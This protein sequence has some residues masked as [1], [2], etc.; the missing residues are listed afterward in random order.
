MSDS[1][2]SR[3][4]KNADDKTQTSPDINRF[5]VMSSLANDRDLSISPP[6]EKLRRTPIKI[7]ESSEISNPKKMGFYENNIQKLMN[8]YPRQIYS[9]SSPGPTRSKTAPKLVD[10]NLSYFVGS[11]PSCPIR[12]KTAPK[13]VNYN[14]SY[15]VGSCSSCIFVESHPEISERLIGTVVE[16]GVQIE[17]PW[18]GASEVIFSDFGSKEAAIK[19]AQKYAKDQGIPYGRRENDIVSFEIP[20]SPIEDASDGHSSSNAAT[21]LLNEIRSLKN[22][23]KNNSETIQKEMYEMRE[24]FADKLDDLRDAMLQCIQIVQAGNNKNRGGRPNLR[25]LISTPQW[26]FGFDETEARIM[27]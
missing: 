20:D 3:K 10:F 7:E 19:A 17:L 1:S 8:S 4:R 25:P 18:Y 16:Q 23:I 22:E 9:I 12:S 15:F 2:V 26:T 14:L 5:A 11:C 13:L 21:I 27:K 24:D 6:P